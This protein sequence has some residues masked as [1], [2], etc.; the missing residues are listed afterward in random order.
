M[1]LSNIKLGAYGGLAGGVVFGATMIGMLP[2][3]CGDILTET[4]ASPFQPAS[5]IRP[6]A[7]IGVRLPC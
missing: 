7:R 1:S 6:P 5:A 2:M 3:R 4:P